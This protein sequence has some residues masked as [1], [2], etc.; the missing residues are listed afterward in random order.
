MP[1][2]A[3]FN[4]NFFSNAIANKSSAVPASKVLISYA[5]KPQ[6]KGAA[7]AYNSRTR[8]SQING[9]QS[10]ANS[11]KAPWGGFADFALGRRVIG[12]KCGTKNKVRPRHFSSW[13]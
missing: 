9:A 12:K 8:A 2:N 7:T 13:F 6:G 11:I 4:T 3:D 1:G 10:P 5:N